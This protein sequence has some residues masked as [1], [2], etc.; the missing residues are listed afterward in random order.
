MGFT[1]KRQLYRLTFADPDMEGL[2]VIVH[3]GSM[4][5]YTS[6]ASLVEFMDSTKVTSAMLG[7]ID[8]AYGAFVESVV[9]WN[10]EFEDGTPVPVTLDGLKTQEFEFT[11]ELMRAWATKVGGVSADLKGGS[12]SGPTSPM[13]NIPMTPM[14]PSLS[15]E[16]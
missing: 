7:R 2:E 11:A 8:E 9:S 13:P 1:P 4:G 16:S 3:K 6:I 15:Q 14:P 5:S 10:L 12:N